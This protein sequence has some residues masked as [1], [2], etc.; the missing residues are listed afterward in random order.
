MGFAQSSQVSPGIEPV[1]AADTLLT[2]KKV[3]EKDRYLKGTGKREAAVAVHFLC[4]G[5]GR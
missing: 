5:G 1:P 4:W 3:L 2:T